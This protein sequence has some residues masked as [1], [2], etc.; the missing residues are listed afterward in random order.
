MN[1]LLTFGGAGLVLVGCYLI[2][3]A[4]AL[5]AAGLIMVAI[6]LA[7]MRGSYGPD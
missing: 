1:D 5:V 2:A 6:G 3:P 4:A 7:R